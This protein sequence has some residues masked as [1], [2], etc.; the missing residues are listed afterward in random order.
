MDYRTNKIVHK[1]NNL[2]LRDPPI[3]CATAFDCYVN[4]T[5]Q[6][7]KHKDDNKMILL[8]QWGEEG[9]KHILR[10]KKFKSRQTFIGYATEKTMNLIP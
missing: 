2:E 7:S 6:L 3:W 10:N 9:D 4:L 1:V 5:E 8:N